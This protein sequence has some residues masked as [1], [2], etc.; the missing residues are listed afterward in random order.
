MS[1]WIGKL[2]H[3]VGD[4]F[5]TEGGG[6]TACDH[7]TET[8]GTGLSLAG[9]EPVCN[10]ETLQGEQEVDR[11]QRIEVSHLGHFSYCVQHRS[12]MLK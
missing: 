11:L 4:H 2:P 3:S 10:Q 5:N 1:Y 9:K 6:N 7:C 12:C 8:C